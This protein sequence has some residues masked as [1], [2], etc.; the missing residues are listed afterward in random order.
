MHE[1][2]I[3]NW[4]Q[5][6]LYWEKYLTKRKTQAYF[7]Y[8]T[9]VKSVLSKNYCFKVR[10]YSIKTENLLALFLTLKNVVR[11]LLVSIL[12]RCS[13]RKNRTKNDAHFSIRETCSAC[14]C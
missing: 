12:L 10:L 14:P 11:A 13:C 6:R 4:Y 3:V 7:N 2:T 1:Q 8:Y 9:H 5:Q